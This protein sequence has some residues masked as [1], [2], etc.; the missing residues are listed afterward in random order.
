[1]KPWLSAAETD[2][3]IETLSLSPAD[4]WAVSSF[5]S[6]AFYESSFSPSS[7]WSEVVVFTDEGREAREV[8]KEQ[9]PISENTLLDFYLFT[10]FYRRGI[11]VDCEATDTKKLLQ[12]LRQIDVS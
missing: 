2:S 9:L 3:H 11:L 7:S 12:L 5:L 1:M 10:V 4:C 8:L 6:A